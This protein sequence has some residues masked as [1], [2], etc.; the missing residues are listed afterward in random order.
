[1]LEDYLM[2]NR[3]VI[4][5]FYGRILGTITTDSTGNKVVRDFYG[6]ILGRYDKKQNVTRDFYG[7]IVAKG[8]RSAGLVPPTVK[9]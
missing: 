5:D 4:K 2:S 9:S 7:R 3:E 1:M 8:D 6:R